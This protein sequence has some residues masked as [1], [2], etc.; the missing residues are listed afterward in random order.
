[1][2]EKNFLNLSIYFAM[3]FYWEIQALMIRMFQMKSFLMS[4]NFY[5]ESSILLGSGKPINITYV[6][7]S[8]PLV[9]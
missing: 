8:P 7:P 5:F 6:A 1:M 9:K 3:E 2:Y 4:N